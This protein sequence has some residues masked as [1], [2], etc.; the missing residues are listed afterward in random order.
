VGGAVF[1]LWGLAKVMPGQWF[2]IKADP[3]TGLLFLMLGA[4]MLFFWFTWGNM[5]DRTTVNELDDCEDQ[6][7]ALKKEIRKIE[8]D[9]DEFDRRLPPHTGSLEVRLRDAEAELSTLE[10]LLPL[11]HNHQAATERH[12]SARRRATEAAEALRH[13]RG[14]WE[15]TL[16]HL[17]ITQSLSPK[18]I[19]IMAE[20]YDSL[21][22]T[23][24]RMQALE[25]ELD[26][27]RLELGAI[28]QRVD[29]LLRQ[30]T[31]TKKASDEVMRATR[32]GA[33]ATMST[34]NPSAS[35]K[36]QRSDSKSDR[37]RDRDRRS[38]GQ[39]GSPSANALSGSGAG[40]NSGASGSNAVRA[41]ADAATLALDQINRLTAM[42]SE[43][44]QY[45]Q[46][47][48]GLKEEDATLAK[49]M[50]SLS[51]AIDRLHRS[52]SALLAEIGC[53]SEEQL[54]ELLDKKSKHA[55]LLAQHSE[56]N[57]RIRA[58]IGGAVAY[59][60]IAKHLDGPSADELEKRW[61]AVLQRIAQAEKR[62]EQLHGRQGEI[63]Q[64]M[65]S[66]AADTR[67]PDAK[68]E[69]ACV[70]NQL[71]ACA[72]HWQTLAATTHMLDKVCEVY[73][74]ERQ[75]ETLREASAFLNQLTEGKYLRVWTPLG[76]N[77]LRIDNSSGQALPLEVLSRGTRETVF[78]ALRLSLAAAYARRGVML[79]LVLDDVFVNFDRARTLAAARVLRD[80]AALGHQ[81]IMFT[82]HEHIMRIFYE[83]GVEVRVLP[84]QGR[85]GEARIYVPEVAAPPK[86]IVVVEPEPQ[87]VL[88]P[89]PAPISLP[90]VETPKLEPVVIIEPIVEPIVVEQPVVVDKPAP[91]KP[92]PATIVHVVETPAPLPPAPAIDWL[93][94]EDDLEPEHDPLFDMAARAEL[95]ERHSV[96]HPSM[97]ADLDGWIESVEGISTE[98]VPPNVED[99]YRS[100][101]IS[102]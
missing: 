32:E 55:K 98:P 77:Q 67:L 100:R 33:A 16:Q 71:K 36:D 11:Q 41:D 96:D 31:A 82:C 13:A 30:A 38:V 89:P 10:T 3:N 6:L 57:D 65:K 19:R 34:A 54:H 51:K 44:E 85:S 42:I 12:K 66:L 63:G 2:N 59:D 21:L 14:Q 8:T 62:V 49:Q 29:G 40:G 56:F 70:E 83:I 20:G 47:R 69:L 72:A 39:S 26:Q 80:F 73:E 23:R 5:L 18:N 50:S 35:G 45:I 58:V 22:Q 48:K 24:R 64:E 74:T 90:V 15:K 97:D 86:K 91:I 95:A 46:Q 92:V 84:P 27:R 7:E 81:V 53:E 94:Y 9:R 79:P 43:Q 102:A 17:G 60:A 25:D 76:K 28:T 52:H 93:W 101:P 99:Y 75:P 88:A 1:A 68:L 61:D 87:P 4:F 78:I 37:E